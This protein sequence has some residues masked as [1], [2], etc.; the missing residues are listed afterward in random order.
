MRLT[1]I[2]KWA[3]PSGLG[4][5]GLILF[6]ACDHDRPEPLQPGK[7]CTWDIPK[8]EKYAFKDAPGGMD[9]VD[10]I[11]RVYQA[12]HDTTCKTFDDVRHPLVILAHGRVP[13][14]VPYTYRGMTFIANH[15]ASWGDIVMSVNLDVVNSLQ[16]EETQWGIP[17]R[18]ELVLAAAEYMIAEARRPGSIFFQRID[19][20]RIA[21]VGH[22][23]GGG[24][25]I[26]A[27][28]YNAL[29]NQRPIKAIAT[30][31]PA[32]FGTEPLQPPIPHICLYGTWDGDLYD[33]E[34]P[35]IWSSGTRAAPRELVE[36]YGANHYYFTDHVT[37]PAEK[38]EINRSAHHLLA[39]GMV[40]AWLDRY[41]RDL[42]RYD[43]PQY[44]TGEQK[45]GENLEYYVSFQDAD[46]VP[47]LHDAQYKAG[48]ATRLMG[49]A[50]AVNIA[51]LKTCEYRNVDLQEAPDYAAGS[52]VAASWDARADGLEFRFAPKDVSRYH[53]FCFRASQ[54]HGDSLNLLN[55]RKDFHVVVTDAAGNEGRVPVKTYMDGLQYPDLSGSLP[56][57]D[58]NNYKQIM[59]G[60][61]IPK[62][63]LKGVDFSKITKI[64][65]VFDRPQ[66]KGFDN[67]SGA[68]K[69]TDLEFS[70]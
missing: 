1:K 34:G 56:P 4:L 55:Q 22:S 57:D 64:A 52:A 23:R 47:I 51:P 30:L 69:V 3:W 37:Y 68:I 32:S 25:V 39:K 61:R 11:G 43:W 8:G 17:H 26:F 38:A 41:L 36:I 14:E 54:I 66:D 53:F 58:V 9:T 45:L 67:L 42:D 48:D 60:F 50:N 40:N 20:T 16:G 5:L 31:S 12:T 15:L 21:L 65:F 46:F 24:A 18:G 59:R 63:D 28:N 29:H 33:G 13:S 10:L 44:L 27:A 7:I 49:T 70:N 6:T 62:D 2:W 35:Q 19:T